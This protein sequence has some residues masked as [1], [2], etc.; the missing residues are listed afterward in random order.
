MKTPVGSGTQALTQNGESKGLKIWRSYERSDPQ[1]ASM[2]FE[3]KT[4]D[5]YD[6][7]GFCLYK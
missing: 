6:S 5:D 7:H 2:F 4:S 3:K 1:I